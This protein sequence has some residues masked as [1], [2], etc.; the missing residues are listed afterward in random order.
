MTT[1]ASGRAL[2][3]RRSTVRILW[4]AFRIY[5]LSLPL[6]V[7]IALAAFPLSYATAPLY[8]GAHHLV[9]IRYFRWVLTFGLL[10]PVLGGLY[11][12]IASASV[13]YLA[14][15]DAGRRLSPLGLLRSTARTAPRVYLADTI[16]SL[17]SSLAIL[18]LVGAPWGIDRRVRWSFATQAVVLDDQG[19]REALR[20]CVEL[21]KDQSW[22]SF[23]RITLLLLP[24]Y[25][26]PP[27]LG[28]A[29]A[30]GSGEVPFRFG[31]TVVDIFQ[32]SYMSIGLNLHVL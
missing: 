14:M 24:T 18:T 28:I 26:G 2:E 1:P 27:I 25:L 9:D 30:L 21:T 17:A 10:S 3:G 31:F 5:S 13:H 4:D 16:S 12:V 20:S 7:A 32:S 23:G 19:V 11:S 29:A 22:R 8:R 15:L 6:F